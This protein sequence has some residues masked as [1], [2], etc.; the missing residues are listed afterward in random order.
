LLL[1]FS[2][3]ARLPPIHRRRHRPRRIAADSHRASLGS[4]SLVNTSA[5]P[6]V[7]FQNLD[8][9]AVRWTDGFWGQRFE[10]CRQVTIPTMLEVM[11]KPDNSA[12]FQNLAIAAGLA[13]G[14]FFGNHWSDGD[15]YKWIEAAAAVY[16][17]T[18]DPELDRTM[19]HWIEVIAKAQAPDGYISTQIQLTDVP[20]WQDVKYHELYNMGHLLTAACIHH[21]ATGKD[22]FLSIARKLGRL[23][24]RRSSCRVPRNWPISASTRRTSW[25]RPNCTAPRAIPSI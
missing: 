16:C 5:S 25:V 12:N 2:P 1:S 15:C 21:R 7:K 6:H 17:V 13:E 23:P 4:R 24:V 8:L 11:Q 20:R 18:G 19:D 9:D 10:L 22:N 14:K 3:P